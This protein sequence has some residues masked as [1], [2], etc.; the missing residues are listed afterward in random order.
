MEAATLTVDRQAGIDAER[1]HGSL[2]DFELLFV[3]AVPGIDMQEDFV[4]GQDEG[5][6]HS[7][8]CLT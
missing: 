6:V 4:A 3:G 7:M 2:V 8:D 5:L 1:L